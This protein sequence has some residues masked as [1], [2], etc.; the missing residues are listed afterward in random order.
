MSLFDFEKLQNIQQTN[1]NLVQGLT[2]NLVASATKLGK[3]QQDSVAELG[4]AQFDYAGK[5][6][7]VRDIKDLC[8]LQSAF[9]SPTAILDRHLAFNREVLALL[10]DSQQQVGQF[11]EQQIAAGSQQLNEVIEQLAGNAPAGTESAVTALKTAVNNANEAY[12]QAQKAAKEAAEITDKAVKQAAEQSE[13][14][15]RQ[16]A[17][18]AEKGISAATNAAAQHASNANNN[19]KNARSSAKSN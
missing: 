7:A 19:A 10:T 18:T 11:T 16:V 17:E 3:L 14:A 1:L 15:A 6:L 12:E 9:F 8:E 13:K 5:L 4:A 2:N